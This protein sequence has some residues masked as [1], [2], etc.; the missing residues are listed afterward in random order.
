MRAFCGALV[1]AGAVVLLA[2]SGK[3]D[4][5]SPL[6]AVTARKEKPYPYPVAYQFGFTY[7][8]E[9]LREDA[10]QMQFYGSHAGAPVGVSLARFYPRYPDTEAGAVTSWRERRSAMPF[11]YLDARSRATRQPTEWEKKLEQEGW[12]AGYLESVRQRPSRD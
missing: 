10:W 1:L 3:E 12:V 6:L 9:S 4:P 5:L 8:E 2:G 7:R 11:V